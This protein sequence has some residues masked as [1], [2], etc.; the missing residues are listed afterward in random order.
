MIV[1]FWDDSVPGLRP[2]SRLGNHNIFSRP[3]PTQKLL[4]LL[5]IRLV[6]DGSCVIHIF[7]PAP[8]NIVIAQI[9]VI[10]IA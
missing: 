5:I 7:L 2:S 3:H 8:G 9:V 6:S 1:R 10:A 4:V